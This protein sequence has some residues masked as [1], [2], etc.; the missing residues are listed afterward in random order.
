MNT[1]EQKKKT[2]LVNETTHSWAGRQH[3]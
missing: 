1:T 2:H 3:D